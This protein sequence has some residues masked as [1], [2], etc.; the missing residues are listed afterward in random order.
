MSSVQATAC[1]EK[2]GFAYLPDFPLKRKPRRSG[3][4]FQGFNIR[5]QHTLR[6]NRAVFRESTRHYGQVTRGDHPPDNCGLCHGVQPPSMIWMDQ[7]KASVTRTGRGRRTSP[8]TA[9]AP[10]RAFRLFVRSPKYL[11][12]PSRDHP[13]PLACVPCT[14]PAPSI[15]RRSA[16]RI[17]RCPP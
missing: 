11:A 3:A 17:G 6:C 14:M 15:E 2:K 4:K 1:T 5:F 9:S 10:A 12:F 16:V 13:L 7:E 8:P